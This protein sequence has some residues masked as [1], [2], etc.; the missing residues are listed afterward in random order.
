[1]EV[2]ELIDTFKSL[3]GAA[4][5]LEMRQVKLK[6]DFC[7]TTKKD[8]IVYAS[9]IQKQWRKMKENGPGSSGAA[10]DLE[11]GLEMLYSLEAN[12]ICSFCLRL[13]PLH[14]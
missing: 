2:D 5:T 8:V 6:E 7:E 14:L 12:D 10:D 9:E 3:V 11:K 13:S 4:K 1:M